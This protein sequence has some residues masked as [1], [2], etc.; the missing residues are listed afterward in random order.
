MAEGLGLPKTT[1][2]EAEGELRGF[3]ES[4]EAA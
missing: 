2:A 3:L 4:I 1:L